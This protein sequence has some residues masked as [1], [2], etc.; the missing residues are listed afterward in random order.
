M[1]GAGAAAR[2][3]I[4]LARGVSS[5][6]RRMAEPARGAPR[7]AT[8]H[9]V[10]LQSIRGIAALVVCVGHATSVYDVSHASAGTQVAIAVVSPL[11]NGHAAVI[12]FFVLSGYVL[13]L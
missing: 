8:Q 9:V 13:N 7:D 6:A 3:A 11:L 12:L 10:E 4:R 1:S 5:D 2:P